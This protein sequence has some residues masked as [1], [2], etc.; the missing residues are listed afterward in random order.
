MA[1]LMTATGKERKWVLQ[2]M[3]IVVAEEAEE[4]EAEAEAATT[5][6]M[7]KW[8]AQEEQIGAA[9]A[10]AEAEARMLKRSAK[11]GDDGGQRGHLDAPS[12]HE[13]RQLFKN[14]Q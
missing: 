4:A 5:G 12:F 3:Q 11:E 13:P 10:V 2:E 8:A 7:I 9:A 1:D 6:K 14:K